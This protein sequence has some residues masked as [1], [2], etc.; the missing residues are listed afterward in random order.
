[1]IPAYQIKA[2]KT[3]YAVTESFFGDIIRNF[4]DRYF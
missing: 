4:F 1:M 3:P 2:L